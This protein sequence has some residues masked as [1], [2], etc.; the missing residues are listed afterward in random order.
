VR[1]DARGD[2]RN[3]AVERSLAQLRNGP[4]P[5]GD[6]VVGALDRDARHVHA[7]SEDAEGRYFQLGSVAKSLTAIALLQLEARGS[8][9]LGGPLACPDELMPTY[10]GER[11]PLT[12]EDVLRHRTGLSVVGFNG[13]RRFEPVP[14]LADIAAGK[15]TSER[16]EFVDVPL[17]TTG[18]S[19]GAFLLLQASLEADSSVP[20]GDLVGDALR[21]LDDRVRL[22]SDVPGSM[23]TPHLATGH[24]H[25]LVPV[26]HGSL[27]YPESCS[28]GLWAR[29]DDLLLV[30]RGVA[31]AARRRNGPGPRSTDVNDKLL[32][33]V[34]H[35]KMALSVITGIDD[36]GRRSFRHSG[37]TAGFYASFVSYPDDDAHFVALSSAAA[38]THEID[39]LLELAIAASSVAVGSAGAESHD[40]AARCAP[41][42][43]EYRSELFTAVVSPARAVVSTRWGCTIV[44]PRD[45]DG[46]YRRDGHDY[47]RLRLGERSAW[48]SGGRRE[49]RAELARP[50]GGSR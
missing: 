12:Y 15:G 37:F 48:L 22:L 44:L 24:L 33:N 13:Y 10:C 2:A 27:H 36:A 40:D 26:P 29:V 50:E 20:A 41:A 42:M 28:Q 38:T 8:V 23:P 9:D 5:H 31:R 30:L 7:T 17:L 1:D 32:A 19:S 11:V 45:E 16:I 35:P 34:S 21:D 39:R 25:S 14:S 6:I 46:L 43:G 47:P 49:H 18:Y 3:D 4:C